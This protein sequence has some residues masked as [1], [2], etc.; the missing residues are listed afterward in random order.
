MKTKTKLYLGISFLFALIITSWGL[1]TYF[2]R[3]LAK[4]ANVILKD[5]QLSLD[6]VQHMQEDI[7]RLYYCDLEARFGPFTTFEITRDA[8]EKFLLKIEK[9]FEKNLDSEA[10]N[11]TEIGEKASVD[12]LRRNWTEFKKRYA[13]LDKK[14]EY[15]FRSMNYQFMAANNNLNNIYKLNRNAII[16]KN[17]VASATASQAI[18]IITIFGTLSLLAAFIFLLNFPGYIANPIKELT[19]KIQAIADRDFSQRLEVESND[20][21]GTVSAAFNLMANRLEE[22]DKSNLAE[23]TTQKKR[24]ESIINNL[25]EAIILLDADHIII[26]INPKATNLLG[27]KAEEVIGKSSLEIAKGNDLLRELI[28]DLDTDKIDKTPFRISLGDEENYFQRY[29]HTIYATDEWKQTTLAAGS[30]I[31]LKNVTEFKKLDIA[32]TNFMATLSH[33]LKTPLSSINLSL[34]LLQD[35]RVGSI[36]GEQGQ[37]LDNIRH[38]SQRLLKYVNELLDF[39]QIESGNIRMTVAKVVPDQI[40]KMALDAMRPT[41]EQKQLIVKAHVSPGLPMVNADLEKT[42]WIMTNL[43]SNAARF[44]NENGHIDIEV[45]MQ[46]KQVLFSVKDYGPGIEPKYHQKIF[47]RFVQVYSEGNKGGTGLGLTI[48]KD[49]IEAQGGSIWVESEPGNGST[50]RFTLNVV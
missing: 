14:P 21:F 12:S 47:E 8:Y 40:I 18:T 4:D 17:N 39:S 19:N 38:E 7:N 5:N 37:L 29:V 9:H 28:R 3:N 35:E 30:V 1:S 15:N 26:S 13:K 34:K 31:V 20:E 11:I 6:Y 36:T 49:F 23:L 22:Y 10:V 43:L 25:D 46:N 44:S 41:I 27:L 16:K 2:I 45:V 24:I 42:V 50:F 33:E 48:A 32:K